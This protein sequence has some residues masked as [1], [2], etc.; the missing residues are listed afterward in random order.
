MRGRHANEIKFYLSIDNDEPGDVFLSGSFNNWKPNDPDFRMV[1]LG[2]GNYFL[3]MHDIEKY[4]FPLFYKYTR[5]S[6]ATTVLDDQGNQNRTIPLFTPRVTDHLT[7]LVENVAT[8][9]KSQYYPIIE[10]VDD[11]FPMDSLAKTRRIRILLP[12]DYY[13]SNKVY[14]TLYL[15]DG[16]N[17]WDKSAPFGTWGIDESLTNMASDGKSDVVI[18][19]ID[20]G[21]K[22]RIQ[23]FMPVQGTKLGIA[24]GKRYLKFIVNE[25]KPF[26]EGKYRV[27]GMRKDNAIGGSSMGGLISTYAALYY[28][29]MFSKVLIFSPSLWVTQDVFKELSTAPFFRNMDIYLYGGGQESATLVKN[30]NRFQKLLTQRGLEENGIQLKLSINPEGMHNEAAWGHEFPAAMQWLFFRK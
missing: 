19:A 13:T 22:A 7:G 30:L 27:S 3:T 8:F 25:L 21:D 12:Y 5:G 9:K 28:P 2:D 16:Q 20:H 4:S 23:E 14:R 1:R 11:H 29:E 18:V 26:I 17:L 10:I 6:W 24:Q 15:Q